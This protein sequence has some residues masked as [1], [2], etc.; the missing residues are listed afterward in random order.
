MQENG[1]VHNP[2]QESIQNSQLDS[3]DLA[4]FLFVLRSN[5]LYILLF[6]V[7]GGSVAYLIVRYTKPLYQSDS[8]IKLEYK[9]EANALGLVNNNNLQSMNKLSGE[10]E[11]LK[12]KL[13]FT[14]LIETINYD[15]SYYIYGTYL[16]DE[17][18]NN[19]PFVV[20]YKVK[21]GSMFNRPI[22]L[23]ILNDREFELIYD[24]N[25]KKKSKY[26]FGEEISTAELNLLVEKTRHFSQE[27]YGKYFFRIHSINYLLD[28]FR[29]NVKIQPEN[30]NAKTIRISLQDYNRHKARDFVIAIDT[31]YLQY[32]TET[33]NE[34]AV[35]KIDFLEDQIRVTEAGLDSFEEYFEDFIIQNRITSVDNNIASAISMLNS[36]DTQR[37]VLKKKLFGAE[38]IAQNLEVEGDLKIDPF[39]L[40]QLPDFMKSAVQNYSD[41]KNRRN[42]IL[43][44]YSERTYV[45]QRTEE[46]LAAA[47]SSLSDNIKVYLE[48]LQE[49]L[50]ELDTRKR[51]IESTFYQLPSMGSEYSNKRRL[52]NQQLE[53]LMSL[54]RTKM[55]LE[56]TKA[57]TVTNN[58]ILSSASLPN[59][60]IKPQKLMIYS[61]GIAAAFILSFVLVLL[62]YLLNDEITSIKELERLT[63]V[64]I[65]GSVPFYRKHKLPITKLVVDQSPKSAV[66]ESL[67]TIRTNMDFL[68]GGKKL[69][70]VTI[71]STVSG[72][73]KTFV[74]VNL[75][76]I[77]AV[78]G[79]K[80]C[81]MD[82]DMRK[83]KV[84]LAFGMEED[85]VGVST[86]L[87][88]KNKLDECI[89]ET[90][91]EGLY[92]IDSGP[93]PPNP[94]E[95][96][97]SEAFDK[98]LLELK[99]RFDL[100]ILDTPPV[101]LV[102]DAVLAM[103]KCDLQL[104]VVKADYSKR[105][106]AKAVYD[107]RQINKFQNLT[108]IFNAV[109]SGGGRAGYGQ[110]SYGY[111]YGYGYGYYEERSDNGN[112]KLSKSRT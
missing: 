3:F 78:S 71:T 66:S 87:I 109:K 61:I 82:L 9:N 46:Q 13:F 83:P 96:I 23:E 31:L 74:A 25:G 10:I 44:T 27:L 105:S 22:D 65:L 16:N 15:V 11:L 6:F 52:Y 21:N 2:V 100:I 90:N 99:K 104:Y 47:A 67:R 4:K 80:V 97:M 111:G 36:L 26:K 70:S 24:F 7:V 68:S 30:L 17:R 33:K 58:V 85:T 53:F 41:L 19:S 106:F 76:A 55:Q 51:Q 112:Q 1:Q 92:Y 28:Y 12:S 14:R 38:L 34:T 86:L 60:P 39:L 63:T 110:G 84:H 54:M 45:A 107:L 98:L 40:S 94:S 32:T 8:I 20:S 91:T 48:F 42:S 29:H 95:L 73:G 88:G 72:E 108:L 56:I 89:K 101:G 103:R 77:F 18:Y 49:D 35:K 102:T 43:R 69:T 5:L 57:G 75:G 64:P 81:I 50:D 93:T 59:I 62:R 79:Q 37:Y